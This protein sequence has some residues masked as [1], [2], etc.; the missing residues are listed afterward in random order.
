VDNCTSN[1]A[2]TDLASG[3]VG[4]RS[5]KQ[6][7]NGPTRGPGKWLIF[8]SIFLTLLYTT[9][10]FFFICQ[11]FWGLDFVSFFFIKTFQ[12]FLEVKADPPPLWTDLVKILTTKLSLSSFF[13]A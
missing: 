5:E 10:G 4:S 7:F 2:D 11:Y 1:P 12:T 13:L 3:L 9:M 8:F 6:M